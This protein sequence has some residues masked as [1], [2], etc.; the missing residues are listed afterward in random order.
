MTIRQEKEKEIKIL[1]FQ[2]SNFRIL[3]IINFKFADA[4]HQSYDF[5]IIDFTIV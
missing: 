5:E 4:L 2:L 1:S 3:T